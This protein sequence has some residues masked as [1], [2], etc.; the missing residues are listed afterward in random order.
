MIE[1]F[2]MKLKIVQ[3]ENCTKCALKSFCYPRDYPLPCKDSNGN[4][5]RYFELIK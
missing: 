4:V 2:G 5:N 3:G 1:I